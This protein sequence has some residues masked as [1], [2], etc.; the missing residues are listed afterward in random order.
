[1]KN[2]YKSIRVYFLLLTTD[3]KQI[4]SFSIILTW[5]IFWLWA[6]CIYLKVLWCL[7]D[8]IL[9]IQ[10]LM[11]HS[12]WWNNFGSFFTF[13]SSQKH[14]VMKMRPVRT[15]SSGRQ[16]RTSASSWPTSWHR[17][18]QPRSTK[19]KPNSDFKVFGPLT[20]SQFRQFLQLAI[21]KVL[22]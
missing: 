4:F 7:V 12:F 1:M 16:C 8:K 9:S 19:N 15:P 17:R 10:I 22:I 18:L 11:R 21:N 3:C 14:L 20:V 2:E 6:K 5:N 13:L